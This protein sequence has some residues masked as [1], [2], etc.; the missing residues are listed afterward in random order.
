MQKPQKTVLIPVSDRSPGVGHG[1]PLQYSCLENPTG[2]RSLRATV[3]RVVKSWTWLKRLSTCTHTHI[4]T[5]AHTHSKSHMA[6]YTCQA[7][8]IH[9]VQFSSVV[10]SC[11]TLWSHGRQHTRPPCPSPT[12]RVYSNSCPLRPWCHPAISSSV[13]PFS[14]HSQSFPASGSTC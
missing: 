3:H 1:N 8:Y 5:H 11:T 14:S 4:H 7:L 6:T 13:I 10:Q 2:Q 12:P 9:S